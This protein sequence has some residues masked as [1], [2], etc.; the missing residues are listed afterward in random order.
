[1]RSVRF[2][3][4]P[5]AIAKQWETVLKQTPKA[6]LIVI[7]EETA[8]D[9][10]EGLFGD[11]T[12]EV[13]QFQLDGETIPVKLPKVEGLIYYHATR[14]LARAGSRHDRRSGRLEDSSRRDV[15]GRRQAPSGN[16]GRRRARSAAGARQ[17]HGLSGPV[18]HG[19]PG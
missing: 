15:A 10:L 2:K 1:M 4:Q 5:E 8:I 3:E 9:Y 12:P 11:V 16:A 18:P 19:F 14:S 7:R 13:V 6:D 17:L